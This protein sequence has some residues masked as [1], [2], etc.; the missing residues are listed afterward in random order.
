MSVG[1]MVRKIRED[2]GDSL[3]DAQKR[4]GVSKSTFQR[5]EQGYNVRGLVEY[6]HKIAI[7]YGIPEEMLL[8][9]QTPKGMFEGFIRSLSP[10][11]R[12][13]YLRATATERAKVMFDFVHV[14][15][16]GRIEPKRLA[17]EIGLPMQEVI[18]ALSRWPIR[19]PD[20]HTSTALVQ[21]LTSSTGLEAAWFRTGWLSEEIGLSTRVKAYANRM[22]LRSKGGKAQFK[23]PDSLSKAAQLIMG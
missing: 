6:L 14:R 2:H 9:A 7:G 11:E 20:M 17:S 10:S 16:P 12:F 3:L 13:S 18:D 5:I 1:A 4:T 19:E 8:E 15:F 22:I 21:A 23:D